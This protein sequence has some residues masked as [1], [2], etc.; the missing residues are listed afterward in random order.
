MLY[1]LGSKSRQI[2]KNRQSPCYRVLNVRMDG[3]GISVIG[4]S[5][6]QLSNVRSEI[7][8]IS[9][10]GLKYTLF[11][12]KMHLECKKFSLVFVALLQNSV[13]VCAMSTVNECV[14]E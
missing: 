13:F 3:I 10:E 8:F 4:P 1:L 5:F 7:V 6:S 9:M 14:S 12:H 11:S 2:E